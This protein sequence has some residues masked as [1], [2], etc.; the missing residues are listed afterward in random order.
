MNTKLQLLDSFLPNLVQKK[1]ALE[2]VALESKKRQISNFVI[3][4]LP[5]Q[6]R[7][8]QFQKSHAPRFNIFGLLRYGHYETRLHTPFLFS[9]LNPKESH[10]LGHRFLELFIDQ[11]FET[12]IPYSEMKHFR[13]TEE[14]NVGNY[15]QIDIFISFKWRNKQYC[16]AIENKINAVDQ[17]DQLERYYQYMEQQ[18][19]DSIKK[20]IYLSKSGKYP[21]DY[22]LKNSLLNQYLRE[23]VLYLRSYKFDVIRW[24]NQLL[25]EQTPDVVKFTLNQYKQTINAFNHD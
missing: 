20:L 22:S 11:I 13:L 6:E 14:L 5:I 19:P 21:S 25:L 18:F 2:L 23:E 17:E 4:L 7:F 10:Q 16:I 15:G 8:D 3:Q 12:D 9:F 1:Q 24:I